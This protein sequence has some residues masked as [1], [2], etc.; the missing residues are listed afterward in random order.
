[1]G[2]INIVK[3]VK[4]VHP[5]NIILIKIGKFY[6]SYG[7]DAYILAYMFQ[8]KLMKID[9]YNVYSCAFPMQSYA[10]VIAQLENN[11]INYLILDR[12][13]NY[14]VDEKSDN[15]NLNTYHKWFQK[16]Q[17]YINIKNRI[18]TVYDYIM[19]HIEDETT[20]EKLSKMEEVINEA[21]KV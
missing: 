16:A 8:Y 3:N 12:R 10:K 1:M 19:T 20:K 5:E 17:Q 11:K 14:D 18:D 21:R 2:I 4:K 7:K 9:Q 13:N 15:K 6:Y